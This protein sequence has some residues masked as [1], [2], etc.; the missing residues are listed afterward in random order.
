VSTGQPIILKMFPHTRVKHEILDR[1][2]GAWLSI[3][4]QY[5]P[6]CLYVDGFCGSGEYEGGEIGSPQ[7]VIRAA[8]EALQRPKL[9][10]VSGFKIEFWFIDAEK[11]RI[12]H[13][14]GRLVAEA[15]N[16][17][18][19]IV[20]DP[21][22]GLFEEEIKKLLPILR[23]GPAKVP[24]L[25]F[26]DPFGVS[27][28]GLKTLSDILAAPASEIFLL[29][30]VDGIPRIVGDWEINKKL[31]YSIFGDR[32]DEL[33]KICALSNSKEVRREIRSLYR[34]AVGELAKFVISF[35]MYHTPSDPRYDLIFLTNEVKGIEAMKD[36]MWKDRGDHLHFMDSSLEDQQE[37]LN[38]MG[39]GEELW[40]LINKEFSG[41]VVSGQSIT[42]FV[43]QKTIY[44]GP[45]KT[46]CLKI[47]ESA[48]PPRIIVENRKMKGTYPAQATINFLEKQDE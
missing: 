2:L 21:I 17:P 16:R 34:N 42:D 38:L 3:L 41:K 47:A 12:D 26:L 6:S 25:F 39:A 24:S 1:Y 14:N 9:K 19:I 22:H 33:K 32:A 28:F 35:E 46:E 7:V 20:H 37:A 5:F 13:L 11:A 27:G 8:N 15:S 18:E 36:A 45:H 43:M 10:I 31:L 44:R 30:D 23:R 4:C 40:Y 29:F 48:N